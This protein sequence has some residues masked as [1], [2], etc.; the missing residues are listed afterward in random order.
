MTFG[1]KNA[2]G[3]YQRTMDVFLDNVKW[4]FA[5]VYLDDIVTFS[6]APEEHIRDIREVPP[7][8]NNAG[9]SLKLKEIPVL[10]RNHRRFETRNTHNTS[11]NRIP[12]N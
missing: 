4:H 10:Y 9:V 11:Q 12:H 6:K 8:L 5:P 7:L 2:P 1:L 3:T